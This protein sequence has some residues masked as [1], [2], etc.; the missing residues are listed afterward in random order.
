MATKKKKTLVI[1]ESPAKARTLS[2]ILGPEYDIR[3]SV[4]HV[5]DLP[6]TQLG[7]DT[8]R[9]FAP[10]YLVPKDKKAIV[11]EIKKAAE[12][13]DEIFLAT[14][15]DREGEAISW[16][17]LEATNLKDRPHQRVVFHEI[18]PE[19]VK[20]AFEHPRQIDYRLVDAQQARRV[21]DRLVGYQVSPILWKKIRRGLSA[22][23]VQSVALRMVVER[24]REIQAFTPVEYWSIDADMVAAEG[25]DQKS[26]TARL[27]GPVGEKKMEIPNNAESDRLV[28]LLK[29]STFSVADI[30][31]RPQSRKPAA[32]FTTSTLQQ[33]ASR[34][35]GFTARRT[36]AVAQQ[37]YEGLELSDQ[38]QV[39]LITY[40][41]TDSVNMADSAVGE[42]REYIGQKFGKEFVP[43]RPRTYK[44]KGKR[45][46]EAHEAIRPTSAER[47]P[48]SLSAA[49]T[50]DQLRLYTLIWQRFVAC[51]MADAEYDRTTVEVHAHPS[52]GSDPFLLRATESVLTFAGFQGVYE[53]Q[54]DEDAPEEDPEAR[55]LPKIETG[56]ALN[57][58]E[59]K[60]E[61]H[62]TEPPG[63]YSEATLVKAL[64][65]NGI[66]RPSTYAPIIST[67]QDRGYV[68][69][70]GRALVP[71]ELGFVVNDLLI[72]Y[73][74]D[75]F[76]LGFT[77]EMEEELDE[78]ARGERPWEPVVKQFYDPLQV[79]LENAAAAPKVEELT[80]EVC[81]KC[82][83]P[84][85]KKWGR[86]GQFLA[87][88]GYPDCKSTRPIDGEEEQEQ[89]DEK[90]GECNADM[91][92]R[93][94]RFGKFLACTR[95]PDCKGTK[96]LLIKVGIPCPECGKDIVE[97]RTK[98]K[99]TFY[100]CA[101]YPDCEFTS[102]TRPLQVP[103]PKCEGLL[104][105]AG[106][107][108]AEGQPAKCTKCEFKGTIDSGDPDPELAEAMA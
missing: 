33:D 48:E 85:V 51:Q 5:R 108:K 17:L 96:P 36:M 68:E 46:Q 11:E 72:E 38:G 37:L 73:F 90:C 39:G 14:D 97:K 43:D 84:M 59:I 82:G 70:D 98:K 63:R 91:N 35:F 27:I 41:R 10:K 67:I 100:G 86:F 2:G 6:K 58:A 75:V 52:D 18:T 24:E 22:G 28:G 71:Q 89:T 64:E 21:L 66:G 53:V 106:K 104:V 103:C 94:G 4:G 55:G 62:F 3:A 1:V 76:S 30:K 65:E 60:P 34:R 15:P 13:A 32:P 56:D 78:V 61:Q 9:N 25:D 7:V 42:A 40:M 23:R 74:P 99:R 45:A 50:R 49:L 8:D 101:G 44:T 87:C 57:A 26:F 69:R 19:A 54:K 93:M 16:H 20:E 29:N 81:E 47:E 105:G 83:K 12:K 92:V 80:E 77:A 79:D 31:K 88:T 95:Y 102:W 107:A